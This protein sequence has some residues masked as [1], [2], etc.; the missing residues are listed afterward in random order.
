MIDK[1]TQ[2]NQESNSNGFN[3][4]DNEHLLRERRKRDRETHRETDKQTDRER[5]RERETEEQTV[6]ISVSQKVQMNRNNMNNFI[7]SLIT[8]SKKINTY[9][10]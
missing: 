1:F 2:N 10:N 7:V 8:F 9:C 6:N 4:L 5:E 3:I